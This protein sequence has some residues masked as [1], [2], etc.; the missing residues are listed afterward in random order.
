MNMGNRTALR[1]F[2]FVSLSFLP[3]AVMAQF[4][5]ARGTV[6]DAKNK[7][8]LPFVSILVEGKSIGTNTDFDGKFSLESVQPYTRIKITYLGYKTIYRDVVPN[9]TQEFTI[10]LEQVARELKEVNIR[11][12]KR[13][14][15]NRDNPAVELIHKVIEHKKSNR[16]ESVDAYQVER[17]EKIQFALSDISEKFKKKWFMKKFQ[18][19]FDNIDSTSFHGKEILP[20]YL[21]EGISDIY[22]RSPRNLKEIVRGTKTVDFDKYFDQ[23]GIGTFVG[24]LYQDIDIYKNSI[25]ILTN[26]FISPIADAG[27]VFY[28][29]YITDTMTIDTSKCI[30]L[31]FF[32]RN[33]SDFLLHGFLYILLDS[34]YAIRRSEMS[35]SPEINLNFV[36]ELNI[37][38]DYKQVEKGQYMV[39]SDELS[40]DFG[41]AKNHMGLYGQR[42]QTFRNYVLHKPRGDDFYK[43]LPVV[44]QDSASLRTAAFWKKSR[45][46]SLTKSEAGVYSMM[47]SVMN[48]RAFRHTMSLFILVF[49]GY[50]DFG[51]WELGPVNTFY[52]YNPIE[53]VRARFGGR[54]TKKLSNRFNLETYAAYGFKDEKWK[55]YAGATI[56]TGKSS[57]SDWPQQNIHVSYQEETRIPGQELQFVQED[58]IL[59]SIKRGVNDKMLY[60]RIFN[61]DYLHETSGH[62]SYN[63][64]FKHLEQ[65]PAGILY[66]N[67]VDYN[68]SPETRVHT[69]TTSE[70]FL[71]LR[72]APHEQFYQG[73]SYRIPMF[74]QYPIFTVRYGYGMKGPWKGEYEYHNLY[75]SIFKRFYTP[76]IGYT[77]VLAEAGKIIGSVPYPLL[78]IHRA[79]QTFSY[80]LQSYNLMN[81]MEFISDEWVGLNVEHYFNGFFFNKIPL[82]RKLKW[83]ELATVKILYGRITN[84]N[85]PDLHP[86]LFR[87]PVEP[88]GTSLTY[89]LRRQP[90]IE[91]SVGV[92]NILKIFRV[93]LVKRLTYL[94]HPEISTWGIRARFKFDF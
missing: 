30:K 26:Q 27:P 52:S 18:F 39:S 10:Y 65:I 22:F 50:H 33:K 78:D 31:A 5:I 88:D 2:L 81:F 1:L 8:P 64:G 93:D 75:A 53:G 91:G 20:I 13:K 59:L 25:P 24:Y 92:A 58:N 61:A 63:P 85:N 29:Y 21:K 54:T 45:L 74:N 9:T 42:K 57:Y 37:V 80:Q 14:Y 72:Y 23:Q 38:Q 90:Y 17:Y 46:D 73:R 55:Y 87:F 4:T 35:V 82:F 62:F 16:S 71:T 51:L 41:L 12:G 84:Q 60:N 77:D 70:L 44:V 43:G 47:D 56:A 83:R 76:P 36:R 19:V 48:T 11:A 34:T 66:F 28:R 49:A 79:N 68:N 32:P 3:A 15:R 67:P 89:S 40:I 94:D 7:D 69:V 86:G 6:Y